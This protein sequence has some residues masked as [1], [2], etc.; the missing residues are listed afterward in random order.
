MSLINIS[1]LTFAYDGSY[2][3][4]FE[5]VS[6]QIDTDWKL[7]F[8]GRNGRGKTTFLNL[9]LGKYE[10]QGTISSSVCFDYFPF[11]V[12]DKM[13]NTIDIIENVCTDYQLW[14]LN[15]ELSLLDVSEDVLYRPFYTLSNGEQTKVLLAGLFLKGNNFLL[16]DE[17]TNHLDSDA[18]RLVSNY[19]KLKKGFILV[20]HDRQFLDDCID[21]II[22]INKQNIEIQRGN[23]SSWWDNKEMQDNYELAQNR[24]LQRDIDTLSEA[25]KRTAAW[26]DKIERGKNGSLVSGIKAD[27][28]HAGHQAAKMMKRSKSTEARKQNAMQEKAKLLKNIETAD[29][30]LIK[31]RVYHANRL[32][33]LSDI[34]IRYNQNL[35]CENVNF[36]VNQ[37]ERVALRGKNGSG[38]SS[39]LKLVLGEDIPFEGSLLK[40]S[41]LVISYIGQDTSFLSGTLDEF[42]INERI[43]KSV[44]KSMLRKLDFSRTQFDKDMSDFSDGQKKKVLLARSLC[45]QA[46]LYIWDEPLNFVDVISRIQIENLVVAYQPTMIFVEH[47]QSFVD[48][49]ATKNVSI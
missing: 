24:K 33:E 48:G 2:D 35:V 1:G 14:E 29:K 40:G 44:F 30:L 45:E 31:P 34:S 5:E 19:L 16:I 18:R 41:N 36:T 8:T 20:S 10:Y 11:E 7:G 32:L 9:L 17:P 22:A 13:K 43:D 47:D 23:F 25:S 15:R 4:V 46:H 42:A 3:S 28:G 26:S 39:I 27:K 38:K 21:H 6:F 37:G 12:A 49:I